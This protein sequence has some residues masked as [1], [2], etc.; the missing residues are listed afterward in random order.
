MPLLLLFAF[1]SG[2]I[3]I[4]APCIWP[5]LPLIL[6]TSITGGHRKPLGVVL[7]IVVSFAILTLSI[8]YIVKIFPFD[9]NSLRLFAVFVIGFL[10][11]TLLI[12]AL[13]Q[14]VEGFV[15]RISGKFAS[16][17]ASQNSNGFLGGLAIGLTLGIVWTPCA[18]PILATI[19]TLAATTSVNLGIIL[20]TFAYVSGI[21]IPLF[22]FAL[23]G[24][25][26]LTKTRAFSKYTGRIQQIFGVIMIITAVLI[27]TNY[28]KIIQAKLLNA[29][30]SYEKILTKFES[31]QN[32]QNE[33]RNLK[34][35]HSANSNESGELLNENYPAPEIEGISNWINSDPQRIQDLKGKVVLVD[36]WT[37]TCINC[38]RTLPHIVEWN[39]KY[40]DKGL[41]I[42][43]VHTPEFEFEKNTSN[44]E[45]A[46]K[47]FGIT[48]PVAQDNDYKTWNNFNNLYWP[49]KYLIDAKGNVRY[50]HFGEGDY[51]KTEEAIQTLLKEAGRDVKED[52]SQMSDDTPRTRTSPETYLGS[53]RMQYYFP[54]GSTSNGEGNFILANNIPISTFSLGNRW[55][56]MNEYSSA[57]KNAELKYNFSAKN[58]YLVMRSK[59]GKPKKVKVYVDG[60]AVTSNAGKDVVNG[61]AT[62]TDD[63][64]Y[65]LVNL[66]DVENRELLLKFESGVELFAFTFG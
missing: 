16:R 64:L 19:A 11:L 4:F 46:V 37:Y 41:V 23:S 12:P 13:A 22:I 60:K 57:V 66:K 7:G 10:G 14:K 38:I 8:S 65:N 62:V 59:D 1:T 33:L 26:L 20:V 51:D 58:V 52:I 40:K 34:G 61:E 54:N 21:A 55:N 56:I 9:P 32:V 63:R 53:S 3:T 48:Y 28:D 24:K 25:Y 45:K 18:G 30:P 44:V 29:V 15:S 50:T 42:I 43:G 5:L 49:A 6:S 47:Q 27:F 36:F 2:L 39:D 17:F 31:N 35:N